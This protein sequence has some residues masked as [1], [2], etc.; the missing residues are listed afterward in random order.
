MMT[1][2]RACDAG[3]D[4]LDTALSPLAWGTSQPPV[5]SVVA[6]LRGTPYDTGLDLKLLQ[7]IAE[8]FR[9]LREKYYD[10]LGL[11]DPKAEGLTLL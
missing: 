3:V 9:E 10:P 2:L 1:Y 11:I 8:Y 6:A 4:V 7:E 5:E